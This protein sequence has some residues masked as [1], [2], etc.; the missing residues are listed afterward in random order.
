MYVL[1]CF[2]PSVVVKD[3]F[4]FV[5]TQ[6]HILRNLTC[7]FLLMLFSFF[8]ISIEDMLLGFALLLYLD[9]S[10]KML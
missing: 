2:T 6:C 10:I 8:P 9:E 4:N 5:N 7:I 1:M 3:C